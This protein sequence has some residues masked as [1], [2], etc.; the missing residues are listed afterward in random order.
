DSSGLRDG[1]HE[2]DS[3]G[4]FTWLHTF[5]A[6]TVAQVS[7]FYH[8]NRT[9]YQPAGENQPTATTA[10]QTGVYAGGQASFS[11]IVARNSLRAGVYGYAQHENDLFSAVFNDGR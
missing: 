6:K 5:S 7:P 2:T 1:E 10:V 3:Y 11:T 4:A 8:Y 9:D